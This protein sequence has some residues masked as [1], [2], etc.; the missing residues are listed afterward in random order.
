M[1]VVHDFQAPRFPQWSLRVASLRIALSLSLNIHIFLVVGGMCCCVILVAL[2]MT[3]SSTSIISIVVPKWY[4]LLLIYLLFT[5]PTTP[6]PALPSLIDLSAWKYKLLSSMWSGLWYWLWWLVVS[7]FDLLLMYVLVTLL[8]FHDRSSWCR[9][10]S[11]LSWSWIQGLIVLIVLL[12]LF[13]L[14]F[15]VWFHVGC[16]LLV[17]FC[18]SVPGNYSGRSFLIGCVAGMNGPCGIF[19]LL[20]VESYFYRC[21]G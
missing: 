6:S 9:V 7:F 15:P 3:T 12:S 20:V 21:D 18:S 10:G 4:F 1:D 16:F 5:Y 8:S 11:M 17:S 2:V 14:L 19:P 13:L